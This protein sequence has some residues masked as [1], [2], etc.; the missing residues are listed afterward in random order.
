[1]VL[2]IAEIAAQFEEM[3]ARIKRSSKEFTNFKHRGPDTLRDRL[4]WQFNAD[5]KTGGGTTCTA[6]VLYD[7]AS[8]VFECM[9]DGPLTTDDIEKVK[10]RIVSKYR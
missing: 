2:P 7:P 8:G 6:F 9:A 1:M 10:A 4:C 5:P 3:F